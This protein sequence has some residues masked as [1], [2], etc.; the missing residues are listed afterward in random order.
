MRPN[1]GTCRVKDTRGG[2]G[3]RGPLLLA[4]PLWDVLPLY[5]VLG[6]GLLHCEQCG[7]T[8]AVGGG[9]VKATVVENARAVGGVVTF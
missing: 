5:R 3:P 6:G 8:Q 9:D 1:R 4:N 2:L 7:L